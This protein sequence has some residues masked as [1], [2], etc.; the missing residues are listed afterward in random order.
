MTIEQIYDVLKRHEHL[1][2]HAARSFIWLYDTYLQAKKRFGNGSPHEKAWE[3][4]SEQ[5]AENPAVQN[6]Y[7]VFLY[8]EANGAYLNDETA[9][10]VGVTK[11]MHA[12]S[13]IMPARGC[14]GLRRLFKKVDR[15]K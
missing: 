8:C 7:L 6:L 5:A 1:L 15:N 9:V 4:L 10:G 14:T 11:G 2:N 13:K 3:K 12:A